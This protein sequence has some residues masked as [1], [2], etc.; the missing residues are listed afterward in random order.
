MP[1]TLIAKERHL[2][3][4]HMMLRFAFWFTLELECGFIKVGI[5]YLAGDISGG[6]ARC[7]AMLQAFQESIKSYSTPAEKA[8][9]RDLTVKINCY[10]SVLIECR[11]ISISMGNAI[12]FVETFIILF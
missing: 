9:N 11:P 5:M 8:L 7:I 10:V 3:R 2:Q 4:L 1:G 6:N 12:K